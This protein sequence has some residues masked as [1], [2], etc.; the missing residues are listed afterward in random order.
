M[1]NTNPTVLAEGYSYPQLKPLVKLCLEA[2]KSVFIHGHPGVGKSTLVRE[3]AKELGLRVIDIR[4]SQ[5]DPAEIGGTYIPDHQ[6]QIM[7]LYCPD[8]ARI[9]CKEPCLVFLDEMN[10]AVTKLHQAAAY[11]IVLEHRVG[12]FKFHPDTRVVGAGNLEEDQALAVPLSSALRVRCARFI[13]RVDADAWLDWASSQQLTPKITG[14][15]AFGREGA[16]YRNTGE[17]SFPN[18]RSWAMA[19]TIIGLRDSLDET[20]EKRITAACVGQAAAEEWS[21]FNR[22]YKTVDVLAILEKG[23]IPN[24]EKAAQSDPSFIY[25]LTFA[26]GAVVQRRGLKKAQLP[27]LI[28]LLQA[29]G[30]GPE[31]KILFLRQIR[32]SPIFRK[33]ADEPT[34]QP[35]ARELMDLLTK[36]EGGGL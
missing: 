24:L 12:P 36:Y 7:R 3:V 21:T 25:A 18:P 11:Q 15:I 30:F 20:T 2:G 8:W 14:W 4:L 26:V 5:R 10:A 9:A 19:A 6:R 31:F 23:E 16:L 13:L 33:L 34:F 17:F 29:P 27:N 1:A 28:A 32:H 35:V 22:V